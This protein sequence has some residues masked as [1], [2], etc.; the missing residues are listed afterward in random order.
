MSSGSLLTFV[1]WKVYALFMLFHLCIHLRILI[2]KAIFI[3]D[4]LVPLTNNI[5]GTTSEALTVLGQIRGQKLTTLATLTA[6]PLSKSY[7]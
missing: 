2:D 5:T 7:Y 4:D 6:S 3:R 1:F